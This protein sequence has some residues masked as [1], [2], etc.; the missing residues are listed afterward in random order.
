MRKGYAAGAIKAK[1]SERR[2][3]E[4]WQRRQKEVAK[5]CLNGSTACRN[6]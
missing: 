2:R 4:H 3:W 5:K 6:G 1:S